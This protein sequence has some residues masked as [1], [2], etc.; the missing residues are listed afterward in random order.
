MN[1]ERCGVTCAVVLNE[2][3]ERLAARWPG[4]FDC[5]LVDAPCSGQGMFRKSKPARAEW[6][7]GRIKTDALR[8][9]AILEAAVQL[10]RPGGVLVYSTCTFE[11]EENE[12]NIARLVQ[13]HAGW[14]VEAVTEQAGFAPGRPAWAD[15]NPALCR[16]VRLWPHR[17]AGE[18]HFIAKL[19]RP[20]GAYVESDAGGASHTKLEAGATHA[21][22]E[23]CAEHLPQ[24]D[25]AQRAGLVQAGTELYLAPPQAPDLKGLRVVRWGWWIGTLKGKVF[26]PGHALA[27]ALR[28]TE[29][30]QAV[31]LPPDDPRVAS[32]L[33][34]EALSIPGPAGYVL[35]TV[36]GL[37]LGW[38][39]RAGDIIKN[40]RPPGLAEGAG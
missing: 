5:V 28:P 34:G 19:R 1:L 11:P 17:C 10:V 20:A 6:Q 7:P 24:A 13:R 16:A 18:G 39:K 26:A 40:R 21:L 12:G 35:I 4:Y 25:W 22:A 8:Q 27:L 23:F 2:T 33:R 38:G 36:D 31:D 29:V 30:R 15:G 9:G 37:P 3:P 14:Q 32:F